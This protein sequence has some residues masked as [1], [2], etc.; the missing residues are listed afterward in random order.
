M[1]KA[2]IRKNASV[3]GIFFIAPVL[4]EYILAN[5]KLVFKT[6]DAK[7]YRTFYSIQKIEEALRE[8]NG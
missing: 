7:D 8:F 5:K 2:S 4:N 6:I 1:A 3:N